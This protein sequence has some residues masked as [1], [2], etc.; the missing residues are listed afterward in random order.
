MSAVD[1]MTEGETT[2]NKEPSIEWR[3]T[4][5]LPSLP[6]STSVHVEMWEL[7]WDAELKR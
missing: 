3:S 7:R 4:E 6:D 5:E 2:K 1:T